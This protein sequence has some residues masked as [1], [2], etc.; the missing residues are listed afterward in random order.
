MAQLNTC[1]PSLRTWV[2]SVAFSQ[3]QGILLLPPAL[4][5]QRQTNSCDLLDSRFAKPSSS[6]FSEKELKEGKE[7]EED[8]REQEKEQEQDDEEK[9]KE[10]KKL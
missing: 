3:V 7:E 8:K 9:E 1:Y 6:K 4:E 10:E 2:W 5:R